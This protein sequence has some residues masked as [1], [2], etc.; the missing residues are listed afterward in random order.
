M[1]FQ[2]LYGKRL[3]GESFVDTGEEIPFYRLIKQGDSD[4]T[5]AL[6][7]DGD[8]PVALSIPSELGFKQSGEDT[9][10][11][12]SYEP[13]DILEAQKTGMAYVELG[14]TVTKGQKCVSD[15]DGKGV[16]ADFGYSVLYADAKKIAGTFFEGGD[17]GDI[18][19]LDLDDKV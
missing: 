9:V 8:T 16:A 12:E 6:C 4:T 11:M 7:G 18:V 5:Y 15:E 19:L 2:P 3:A 13:G 17:E 14:G 1:G 10:K